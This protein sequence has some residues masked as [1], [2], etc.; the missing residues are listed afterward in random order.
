MSEEILVFIQLD[1]RIAI[2]N[3][4]T[5]REPAIARKVTRD[6]IVWQPG[7]PLYSYEVSI[8]KAYAHVLTAAA[9]PLDTALDTAN[10]FQV[11]ASLNARHIIPLPGRTTR[12]VLFEYGH[13]ELMA[14]QIN[15]LRSMTS[16]TGDLR[17]QLLNVLKAHIVPMFDA[18]LFRIH[19]IENLDRLIIGR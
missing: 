14:D 16:T 9:V 5:P 18:G 17:A 1:R 13:F 3:A 19:Q 6:G 12:N 8:V 2:E 15:L 7:I 10:L 11:C 4:I